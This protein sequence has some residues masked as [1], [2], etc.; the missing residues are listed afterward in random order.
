MATTPLRDWLILPYQISRL[1]PA[2]G[3]GTKTTF[4]SCGSLCTEHNHNSSSLFYLLTYPSTYLPIITYLSHRLTSLVECVCIYFPN[5]CWFHMFQE[6]CSIEIPLIVA[7]PSPIQHPDTHWSLLVEPDGGR[8]WCDAK[9]LHWYVYRNHKIGLGRDGF[10]DDYM[11]SINMILH[12]SDWSCT[13][14]SGWLLWLPSAKSMHNAL[15]P[16]GSLAWSVCRP[17]LFGRTDHV[18]SQNKNSSHV[19]IFSIP[20]MKKLQS[21]QGSGVQWRNFSV[22]KF[23][24]QQMD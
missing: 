7:I 8:T 19:T 2:S 12:R 24:P 22:S 3:F 11:C 18:S 14:A 10:H 15:Y 21:L 20:D 5:G 9:D 13:T 16:I 17:W 4:C 6:V 1:S 23:V